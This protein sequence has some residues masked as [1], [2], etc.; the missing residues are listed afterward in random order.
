MIMKKITLLFI[1]TSIFITGCGDE[2]KKENDSL[3]S[4]NESLNQKIEDLTKEVEDLKFG[5][6][7]ILSEAKQ[8][9]VNKEFNKA[10]VQLQLIIDK[11]PFTEQ[12]D[13]AKILITTVDDK[14]KEIK[15]EEDAKKSLG[16]KSLK[17]KNEISLKDL[18]V[19][20]NSIS[21]N[22]R[23]SFDDYGDSYFYKDAERGNTYIVCK[24]SISSKI[25]DPILPVIS[26]YQMIE[27]RLTYIGN[28]TYKF[29]RWDNYGTY[30]GNYT[31][32]KN[33]FAHTETISFNCGLQIDES[34]IGHG[35]IYIIL[36]KTLCMLRKNKKFSKPP[37]SYVFQNCSQQAKLNIEDF[38]NDYHLLKIL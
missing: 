22:K 11:Y 9:I 17:Q 27:G 30:L 33:D 8:L 29:K 19:K 20:V 23:W 16:F 38:E 34:L 12:F 5:A 36:D 28:F 2:L 26:A 37:V 13:E 3:K 1:F 4:E 25:K 31:D 18:T 10:K 7:K 35:S 15:K 32:Y 21:K 24:I 6:R 14:I